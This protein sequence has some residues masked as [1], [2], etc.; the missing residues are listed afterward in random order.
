MNDT[1]TKNNIN[2][3]KIL[4]NSQY[5]SCIKSNAQNKY[6]LNDDNLRKQ[7]YSN[8]NFI[9]LSESSY[10]DKASNNKKEDLEY[11]NKKISSNKKIDDFKFEQKIDKIIDKKIEK[12]LKS[13]HQDL[14]FSKKIDQ[15][16]AEFKN[17]MHNIISEKFSDNFINLSRQI[18]RIEELNFN[19]DI[20]N[21]NNSKIFTKTMCGEKNSQTSSNIDI[22][23][24][25]YF[26][27]YLKTGNDSDLIEQKSYKND[28]STGYRIPSNLGS[29]FDIKS[30]KP[31]LIKNFAKVITTSANSVEI[32]TNLSTPDAEWGKNPQKSSDSSEIASLSTIKIDLYDIF[33]KPK[34]TQSFLDDPNVNLDEWLVDEVVNKILDLENA[35]FLHGDGQGKPRGI[36]S[37]QFSKDKNLTKNESFSEFQIAND[38]QFN[39]ET[40]DKLIEMIYTV[41]T[42]FL[43]NARWFLSKTVISMIRKIKNSDGNFI[44]QQNEQWNEK[45]MLLGY[46]VEICDELSIA[47]QDDKKSVIGLFGD[48]Y[49][50]YTVVEK[51]DITVL[52]DPFSSKPYIEFYVNKQVG[53]DVTNFN[54]LK[55]LNFN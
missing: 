12:S 40:V 37:Y 49:K 24:K 30:K 14:E 43:A 31:S 47:N 22:E 15:K 48:M 11:S 41:D 3:D 45:P 36:L 21:M 10:E 27:K 19:G 2:I 42:K 39:S 18:N 51:E 8:K 4:S 1:E 5:N 28:I 20:K 35:A 44:W 7:E 53:G 13:K 55:V 9:K 29:D 33:I 46:P 34:A 52:R 6:S 50:A 32:V 38:M 23:Y 16:F 26:K 25:N 17:Q 54:A